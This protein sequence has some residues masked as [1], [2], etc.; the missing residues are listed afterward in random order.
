MCQQVSTLQGVDKHI[1]TDFIERQERRCNGGKVGWGGG[2]WI[3]TS[4]P[5]VF[6]P[7]DGRS[8]RDR[9]SHLRLGAGRQDDR[10]FLSAATDL[11]FL[12]R[13]H[14][15][16][17]PRPLFQTRIEPQKLQTGSRTPLVVS[18]SHRGSHHRTWTSTSSDTAFPHIFPTIR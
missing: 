18:C 5:A 2:G 7:D 14:L 8:Q 16:K 10:R 15:E 17:T 4:V 6:L 11:V 3:P 12:G 13:D 1:E 9:H